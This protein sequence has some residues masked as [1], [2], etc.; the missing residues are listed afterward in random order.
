VVLTHSSVWPRSVSSAARL[1][2]AR[3]ATDRKTGHCHA[4]KHS[5]MQRAGDDSALYKFSDCCFCLELYE[6]HGQKF[7]NHGIG[8]LFKKSLNSR[9]IRGSNNIHGHIVF[10]NI[11]EERFSHRI[12]CSKIT[13]KL[14]KKCQKMLYCQAQTFTASARPL[15]KMLN[16]TYLALQNA[17]ASLCYGCIMISSV[18]S[19]AVSDF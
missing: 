12:T 11:T 14:S 10:K 4:E 16:L 8:R 6:N 7:R 5:T 2:R 13:A 3:P 18:V 19:G 9:W 17:L 1:T 15:S